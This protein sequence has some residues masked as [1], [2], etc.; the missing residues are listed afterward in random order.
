MAVLRMMHEES[1][2]DKDEDD[3]PDLPTCQVLIHAMMWSCVACPTTIGHVHTF[4]VR[5]CR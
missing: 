1:L 5:Q 4:S 2:D 3:E